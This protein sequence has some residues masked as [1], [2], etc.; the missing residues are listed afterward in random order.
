LSGSIKGRQ[1]IYNHLDMML[2]NAKKQAV[3]ITTAEGLNRKFESLMP[4]LEKAKKRGISLKVAAPITL[5]NVKYAKDLSRIADVRHLDKPYGRFAIVDGEQMM[6]LL[7]DDKTVHPNYDVGV[8]L[9][10]DYFAKS[11][12]QMVETAWKDFQSVSKLKF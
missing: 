2:K 5:E 11:M 10:S 9:S 8:W 6:F 12:N 7:L 1:N 3:I 4:T